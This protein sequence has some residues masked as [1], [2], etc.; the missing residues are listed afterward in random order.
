ME[1]ALGTHIRARTER[2]LR[3]VPRRV[4]FVHSPDAS[5]IIH[6]FTQVLR[7]FLSAQGFDTVEI[8]LVVRSSAT[9]RPPG[10]AYDANGS[11]PRVVRVRLRELVAELRAHRV[12]VVHSVGTRATLLARLA[13]LAI[14]PRPLSVSS[15]Y[16]PDRLS[17]LFFWLD[18]ATSRAADVHFVASFEERAQLLQ[19]GGLRPEQV[20]VL[21]LAVPRSWTEGP[22][23]LEARRRLRLADEPLCILALVGPDDADIAFALEVVA[24]LDHRGFASALYISVEGHE[25]RSIS[26][27]LEKDAHRLGLRHPPRWCVGDEEQFLALR[28]ADFVLVPGAN[29]RRGEQLFLAQASGAPVLCDASLWQAY[30][31]LLPNGRFE[32]LSQR[33]PIV[34][35]DRICALREAATTPEEAPLR[36]PALEEVVVDYFQCLAAR[37]PLVA[38]RSR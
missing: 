3:S 8:E 14:V 19:K 23:P 10:N 34:W 28:A 12:Q 22:A 2:L 5:P 27:S 32:H 1:A 15:D 21:P 17:G 29:L 16:H 18:R 37:S 24:E 20:R 26:L 33:D 11:M 36:V 7:R 31:P 13:S 25:I 35:A 38:S 30:S 4:A 9:E 6:G